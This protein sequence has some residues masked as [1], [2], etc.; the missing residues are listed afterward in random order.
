MPTLNNIM[1]NS[2]AS[3]VYRHFLYTF[4]QQK[5]F[6][7]V[8]EISKYTGINIIEFLKSELFGLGLLD[9]GEHSPG[10]R[11]LRR[12]VKAYLL[13]HPMTIHPKKIKR[14]DMVD[15][16][17][18]GKRKLYD[19][20]KQMNWTEVHNDKG[21][22][23]WD[24]WNGFLLITGTGWAYVYKTSEGFR[25]T[26]HFPLLGYFQ[27]GGSDVVGE[28][29]SCI[30]GKRTYRAGQ[31]SQRRLLYEGRRMRQGVKAGRKVRLQKRKP[32]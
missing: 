29:I 6:K 1:Y 12:I 30:N 15:R 20:C 21:L 22:M 19:I 2:G 26:K 5:F 31:L 16:Q 32:C 10:S 13:E 11:T 18:L 28:L 8:K 25:T 14:Q 23:M 24:R 7:K 4:P 17:L 27:L 3:K 9:Q